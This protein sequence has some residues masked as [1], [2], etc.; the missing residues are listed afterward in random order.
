MAAARAATVCTDRAKAWD[1]RVV[2]GNDLEGRSASASMACT[3]FQQLSRV[4][5]EEGTTHHASGSHLVEK[6][7]DKRHQY[8]V[9]SAVPSLEEAWN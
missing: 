2:V 3:T 7:R 6:L 9:R 8:V 5:C 4:F 1:V